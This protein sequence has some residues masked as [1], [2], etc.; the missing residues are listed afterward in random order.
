MTVVAEETKVCRVCASE[1]PATTDFFN[2]SRRNRGGLMTVCRECGKKIAVK[3]RIEKA[4]EV[5]AYN[6]AYQ[7][8]H[9]DIYRTASKKYR[10]SHP[11]WWKTPA[12]S[13]SRQRAYQ[14][15]YAEKGTEYHRLWKREHA[16]LM[17]S[18]KAKR[19]TGG[20][21]Y[22]EHDIRFLYEYQDG[23]CFYCFKRVGDDYHADHFYPA[24]KGGSS[25]WTNI[26]IAC[27]E[28]NRAK[29]DEVPKCVN[30]LYSFGKLSG[31]SWTL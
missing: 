25:D 20:G 9:P 27:P 13:E 8:A 23:R 10:E 29:S 31:L 6:Q 30:G 26:V 14:K 19:R 17:R 11:D 18:Y 5:R 28:C 16:D 3:R 15:W 7:L 24:S 22:T 12:A 2:R 1:L 21:S 4:D